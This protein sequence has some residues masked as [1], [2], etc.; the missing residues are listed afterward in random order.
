ML[1]TPVPFPFTGSKGFVAGTCDPCTV[2]RRNADGTTLVRIDARRHRAAN[3]D[4]SGNRT[5]AAGELCETE[6]EAFETGQSAKKKRGK[7]RTK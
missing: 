3:R 6:K 7:R 5:L 2:L 1:H 4:A